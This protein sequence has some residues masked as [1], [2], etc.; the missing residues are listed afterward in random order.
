[1]LNAPTVEYVKRE[2]L[3][4]R[5]PQPGFWRL[6]ES[7]GILGR[8]GEA[9]ICL[10]ETEISRQHCRF[11]AIDHGWMIEDLAATNGT[12]L[13]GVPVVRAYL[14]TGDIIEVAGIRLRVNI[15]ESPG[16]ALSR[17]MASW[18]PHQAQARPLR[19]AG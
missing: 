14:T 12:R 19:R 4:A 16:A 8:S 11:L 1:M 17:A 3:L 9:D 15:C 13:N 2:L 5:I 7:G 10:N 18:W 6:N